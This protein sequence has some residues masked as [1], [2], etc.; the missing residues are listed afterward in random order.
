MNKY[1]NILSLGIIQGGNAVI[2]LL[3]FPYLYSKLEYENFSILM[4]VDSISLI[5]LSLCIYGC[6]VRGVIKLPSLNKANRAKYNFEIIIFRFL[7]WLSIYLMLI[8]IA[9]IHAQHYLTTLIYWLLIPLSYCLQSNYIYIYLQ[10]NYIL[11][12]L[13]ILRTFTLLFY[14]FFTEYKYET[15]IFDISLIYTFFSFMSFLYL[16]KINEIS[17]CK[18]KVAQIIFHAK[19]SYN[20]FIGNFSVSLFR[21][22]NV[23]ILGLI[24]QNEMV[25]YYGLAERFVK[26]LQSISKPFTDWYTSIITKNFSKNDNALKHKIKKIYIDI[27]IIITII[28]LLIVNFVWF[29]NLYTNIQKEVYFIGLI[30]FLAIPFGIGNYLFGTL[31]F[32]LL[33][34]S[35]LYSKY[36]LLVGVVSL[37]LSFTLSYYFS[38]YGAAISFVFAELILFYMFFKKFNYEHR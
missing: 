12:F 3:I 18:L 10:K 22:S 6:D 8:L 13:T 11:A 4:Y 9:I 31:G 19:D 34:K 38:G 5:V 2:P 28:F 15:V 35:K 25:G 37:F 21:G 36:I 17:L 27:L 20:I 16:L 26:G 30:L 23:I 1:T 29:F 24:G 33:S 7:L 14:V 32:N